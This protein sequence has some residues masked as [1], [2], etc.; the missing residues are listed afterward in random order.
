MFKTKFIAA[1]LAFSS[2]DVLAQELVEPASL[3]SQT[4]PGV[5]YYASCEGGDYKYELWVKL[6][7]TLTKATLIHTRKKKQ[8]LTIPI[9]IEEYS[10]EEASKIRGASSSGSTDF[11]ADG[12]YGFH[13]IIS[14]KMS[15][16]SIVL[17]T[18]SDGSL[19][20]KLDPVNKW[21]CVWRGP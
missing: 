21:Y 10:K 7:K 6:P 9:A 20:Y 16:E 15:E 2:I 13:F 3:S 4:V 17:V 11:F 18:S 8:L 5:R 1:L 19:V 12:F 14:D